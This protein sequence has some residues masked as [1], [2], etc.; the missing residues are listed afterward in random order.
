MIVYKEIPTQKVE[1]YSPDGVFFALVNEY[2]LYDI[3]LQ[4]KNQE[5]EG[6]YILFPVDGVMNRIDIN[7][8][9][10]LSD[11]PKGFFDMTDYY[12]QLLLDWDEPIKPKDSTISP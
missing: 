7:I 8:K 2:E 1:V 9:G 11:W 12:L 10:Q 3:R 6:Y 5:V 4:I